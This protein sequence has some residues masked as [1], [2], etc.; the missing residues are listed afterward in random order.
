METDNRAD[1]TEE[2]ELVF[3]AIVWHFGGE[4]TH[5][6]SSKELDQKINATVI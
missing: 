3:K 6:P 4:K 1:C 5:S 2:L